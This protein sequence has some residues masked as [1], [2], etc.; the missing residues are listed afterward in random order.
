MQSTPDRAST[1]RQIEDLPAPDDAGSG[2]KEFDQA[3][4]IL[5]GVHRQ[6][7]I[8]MAVALLWTGVGKGY[9]PAEVTLADL[10]ARGDGV[11]RNCEQA[12]VLL[13]AAIQKGSPEGRRRLALLRQ[14]GCPAN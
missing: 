8:Q 4:T 3:K 10:Y 7:D 6:R 12:R 13:K 2:Q 1:I 5:K 11:P 9:V 14:Q